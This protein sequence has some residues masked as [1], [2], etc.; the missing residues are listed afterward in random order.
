MSR[1]VHDRRTAWRVV[2]PEPALE[3]I[4]P[5]GGLVQRAEF[6]QIALGIV[7]GTSPEKLKRIP[8]EECGGCLDPELRFLAHRMETIAALSHVLVLELAPVMAISITL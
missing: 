6:S 4:A 8:S 7:N 1:G 5:L 3:A 2:R